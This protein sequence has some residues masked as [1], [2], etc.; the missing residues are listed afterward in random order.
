M[1]SVA[2]TKEFYLLGWHTAKGQEGELDIHNEWLKTFF[3]ITLL[4][5]LLSDPTLKYEIPAMR[6][7]GSGMCSTLREERKYF[8]AHE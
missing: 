8:E 4:N 2:Q 6:L 1:S 5:S 3:Q 7:T